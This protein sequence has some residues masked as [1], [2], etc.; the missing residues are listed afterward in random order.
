MLLLEQDICQ[1]IWL[2]TSSWRSCNFP[3]K[4]GSTRLPR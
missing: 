3:G 4:R 2:L 1:I